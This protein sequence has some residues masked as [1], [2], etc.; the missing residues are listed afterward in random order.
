MGNAEL[1]RLTTQITQL[2]ARVVSLPEKVKSAIEA[3]QASSTSEL[4]TIAS[5]KENC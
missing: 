5:L 1:T 3:L 4:E 2:S